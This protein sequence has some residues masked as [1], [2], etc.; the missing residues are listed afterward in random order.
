MNR[1]YIRNTNTW[2]AVGWYCKKCKKVTIDLPKQ[3]L[4]TANQTE[5]P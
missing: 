1:L 3:D 2:Q 5:N 4:Q